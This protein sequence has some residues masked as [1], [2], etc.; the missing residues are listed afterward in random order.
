MLN[1]SYNDPIEAVNAASESIKLGRLAMQ[2]GRLEASALFAILARLEMMHADMMALRD[3]IAT[4]KE[5]V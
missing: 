2:N 5:K 4:L 3:A 1:P